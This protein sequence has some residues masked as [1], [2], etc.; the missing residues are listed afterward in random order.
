MV[1]GA[2]GF[3][4]S[5][6][7]ARLVKTGVDVFPV[8]GPG[9]NTIPIPSVALDIRDFESVRNYFEEVKPD[10]V[11]HS[12]A[13]VNLAR[14]FEVGVNCLDINSKGALHVLE[15]SVLAGVGK[16]V[17]FSTQ[18]VYGGAKIPY[19]EE[20]SLKPPSAYAI[21]KVV[22]ENFCALY[23][24]LYNLDY[25]IFRLST[26]YGPGQANAR[27]IPTI[28]RNA[29][30]QKDVNLNSGKKKRDYV[31]SEDVVDCVLSVIRSEEASN[32][33][34][35]VGGGMSYS[36]KNLAEEIIRLAGS[37]SSIQL[38]K[39]PDRV[40]EAD[41]MFSDISKAKK[42]LDWKPNYSLEAGLKKTI[43]FYRKYKNE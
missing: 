33:I 36:L 28:I 13:L 21:S 14:D 30:S 43:E 3:I 22:G 35:N 19:K 23:K 39:F 8:V 40:G 38:N 20:Q 1:T 9:S 11:F 5:H 7:V 31:F 18:E 37:S 34:I 24:N 27:L 2:N 25:T 4:G 15:A 29:I 10:I 26:V 12:G 32:E 17:F 42:L 41:N 16:F 6:V